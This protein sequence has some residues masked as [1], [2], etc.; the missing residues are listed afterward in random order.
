MAS[1]LL[2]HT[3]L[4]AHDPE[5][6]RYDARRLAATL[7]ISTREMAALIGYTPTGLGKNPASPRLQPK[8]R[9]LVGLLNRLRALLD[10]RMDLVRIWLKAPHP[11]LEGATPL[12]YLEAGKLDAVETLVYLMESGQPG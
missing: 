12:A 5:T 8:L 11:Y 1:Q 9:E 3:L 6:G 7:G 10:G 4:S 2:D